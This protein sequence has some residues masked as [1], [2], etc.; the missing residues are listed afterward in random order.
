MFTLIFCLFKTC[1]KEKLT[2]VRIG[3]IMVIL[4]SGS[5]SD[6]LKSGRD[7]GCMSTAV[8]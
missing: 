8:S 4:Q 3:D 6:D 2:S 7:P 1:E 5:P